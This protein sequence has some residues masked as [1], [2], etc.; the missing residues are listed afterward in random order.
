LVQLLNAGLSTDCKLILKAQL[1]GRLSEALQLC[2]ENINLF[3][4]MLAGQYFPPIGTLY[5]L[6]GSILLEQNQLADVEQLLKD[7]LELIRW[8]GE[9]VAHRQGY[10]ALAYVRAI[11]GDQAGMLEA[12]QALEESLP[13]DVLYAQALRHRLL[14]RYKPDDLDVQENARTWLSG[15][16]SEFGNLELVNRLNPASTAKFESNLNLAHVIAD[17]AQ[18]NPGAYPLEEVQADLGRQGR[19]AEIHGIVSWVVM[20]AINRT[21]LYLASREK[22]KALKLLEEALDA[23]ASTGLFRVFLD[24]SEP[25]QALLRELKPRLKNEILIGYANRLVEA[26]RLGSEKRESGG[27]HEALLSER[28]LEVLQC[29]ASGLSYEEIGRKLF[30]SLNTIQFHVKHIYRKL[31]V[32]KRVHAIDKA[33]KLSLI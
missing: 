8:T 19:F 20:V 16:E 7:G 2:E 12:V 15:S 4:R 22:G 11:Q 30:L 14:L 27:K 21:V 33:R 9:S 3:N 25:V 5:I 18:A 13:N 32:N 31:Q 6:K 1:Q 10:T 29:L 23:A 26:F 24:E 17:L 28:E